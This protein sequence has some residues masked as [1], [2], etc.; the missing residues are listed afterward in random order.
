MNFQ[1]NRRTASN[2]SKKIDNDESIEAALDVFGSVLDAVAPHFEDDA[3]LVVFC[4]DDYEPDFR[5]LIE[6]KGFKFKRL[7]VWVKPNHGTGDLQGSFAP[8]KE[9]MI[10]AVKGRPLVE[11]R[12]PDVFIQESKEIE[13][14]HPT[15]KPISVLKKIILSTTTEGDMVIDPFAGT[16]SSLVSALELNRDCWG[17]ELEDAYFVKAQERMIGTVK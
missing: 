13:T 15:E 6:S 16:G 17:A 5:R 9:L 7:L 3:H 12:I 4:N 14:D 1:S 2:K 8:Q 11:P 10:H